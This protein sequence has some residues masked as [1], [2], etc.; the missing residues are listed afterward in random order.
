VSTA[1]VDQIVARFAQAPFETKIVRV[2][3]PYR[4]TFQGQMLRNR[5]PSLLA[6]LVKRTLGERQ[7]HEATTPEEYL[8]DLWRAARSPDARVLAYTR[9]GEHYAATITPTEHVVPSERLGSEWRQNVLVVYSADR[10]MIR[11]GYMFTDL[12]D[13]DLSED[14]LWLR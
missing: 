3:V 1:E 4:V 6:H 10:S 8:A 7:W 12:P 14:A 9:W 13:I 2:P 5:E 11:T